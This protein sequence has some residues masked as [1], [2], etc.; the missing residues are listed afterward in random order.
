VLMILVGAIAASRVQCARRRQ[1]TALKGAVSAAQLRNV[2]RRAE[3][4]AL[5]EGNDLHRD[6]LMAFT[7]DDEAVNNTD[8]LVD[9][10]H[11]NVTFSEGGRRGRAARFGGKTTIV[12]NSMPLTKNGTWCFW[13]RPSASLSSEAQRMLDANGCMLALRNQ[14]PLAS[15][16]D[17]KSKVMLGKSN[18]RSGQWAHAALSWGENGLVFYVNGKIQATKVYSG[19]PEW[20]YRNVV[21]GSRWNGTDYG[22]VGDIDEVYFYARELSGDEVS[23]LMERGLE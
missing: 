14:K 3:I 23:A 8:P 1:T 2:S 6:L 11:N 13:F 21:V 17:G 10:I 5:I 19:E 7:F 20:E 4:A 15:F 9:P 12:L 22:F 18:V 16:N